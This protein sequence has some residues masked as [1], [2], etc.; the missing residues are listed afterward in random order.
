[1][2]LGIHTLARAAE[3]IQQDSAAAS[4]LGGGL[5]GLASGTQMKILLSFLGIVLIVLLRRA[6]LGLVRKRIDDAAVQYRWTK[7]TRY[8][9]LVLALLALVL[10]WSAAIN[11]LG[12]FLGLLSAG[13]AIALKDLVADF[14]G[15]V[16]IVARRPFDLGDRIQ[17]GPHRGDVV[18]RGIFQFAMMEIGNWV[19]ADQS[20]GRVI[21][22]PN[23]QVFTE[24]LANYTA[25][26]PYLWNELPV[27]VTFE[28]DWKRAKQLLSALATELTTGVVA[29]AQGPRAH[30][31]RRLLINRG[32]LTP[33]VYTSVEE[34]GVLLTIRYLC[35]PRQRRGTAEV[36][37]ERILE[38]FA[39]SPDIEFAYPTQRV[40]LDGPE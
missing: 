19:E 31:D 28:S 37:W 35:R 9:A 38:A 12:T 7:N 30:A 11:S 29:E 24:P 17:I 4:V 16:F 18:D 3:M 23:A 13:L 15:W 27:L 22:V 6:L 39:E 33:A 20:T 1:M 2:S 36:F 5:L 8:G 34:A 25:G 32:R 26:F 40:L 21:H 14:A 10:V